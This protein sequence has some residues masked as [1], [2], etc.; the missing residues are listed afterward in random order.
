MF[1]GK[2]NIFWIAATFTKSDIYVNAKRRKE[3]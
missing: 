2:P 1:Q 3:L